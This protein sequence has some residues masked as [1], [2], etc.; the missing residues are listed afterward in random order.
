MYAIL[1]NFFTKKVT[2]NYP[3]EKAILGNRFRGEHVLRFYES[4]TERCIICKLCEVTCP[5]HAITI[6]SLKK[7]Y[8]KRESNR[9]NIDM[10]KCIFC[11]ACQ[12]SCPVDAVVESSNYNYST[13][14]H[15]ELLYDKNK[16]LENGLLYEIEVAYNLSITENFR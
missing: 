9:Y 10:T 3:F 8:L 15:E 4:G 16:L 7:T 11:G 13:L 5:A 1:K 12:D 14:L 2:L 6:D